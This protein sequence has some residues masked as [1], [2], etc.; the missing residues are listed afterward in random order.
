MTRALQIPC[1]VGLVDGDDS[2]AAADHRGHTF[3]IRDVPT[4][5]LL[6]PHAASSNLDSYADCNYGPAGA[7]VC[8]LR[9]AEVTGMGIPG[10]VWDAGLA[11][12]GAFSCFVRATSWRATSDPPSPHSFSTPPFSFIPSPSSHLL[13]LSPEPFLLLTKR[14]YLFG[15]A[16]SSRLT[17][18]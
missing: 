18:T 11:L 15:A 4:P 8:K 12:A 17:G 14:R 16:N 5:M 10:K 3:I 2:A 13:L 1:F 6:F 9:A 7:A